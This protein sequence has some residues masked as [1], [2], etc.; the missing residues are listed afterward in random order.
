MI[1]IFKATKE[2]GMDF[3]SEYNRG[4]FKDALKENPGS[5]WE[6]RQKANP[7]S[8]EMRGYVF[9]ALIPFL[10]QVDAGAWQGIT[11]DQVYESLKKN[12][13]YFEAINPVTKRKERFGQS[14]LNKS[15]KNFKAME[16][17]MRI[18]E[19]V[20]TNY[21][22]KLPDP[23]EYKRWRDDAPLL[24]NED[25]NAKNSR[26]D[27]VKTDAKKGKKSRANNKRAHEGS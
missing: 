8:D 18:G 20:M 24:D 3:Q 9:G 13:N 6:L 15:L 16:F 26:N 7:V 19:W 12:F 2:G 1:F 25:Q 22:Q 14:V 11:D 23:E 17:V 4:R 21:G 5:L 10:R 27:A